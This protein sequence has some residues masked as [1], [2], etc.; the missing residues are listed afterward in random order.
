MTL[1]DVK[2]RKLGDNYDPKSVFLDRY[3]YSVW[4]KNKE[5]STDKGKSVDLFDIPPLEVMM[6]KEKV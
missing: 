6:K 2:K 1:P 3:G 4:S 5:E